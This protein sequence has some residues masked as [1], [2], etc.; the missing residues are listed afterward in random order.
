M[1]KIHVI[2][3]SEL[4]FG[5]FYLFGTNVRLLSC[6]PAATLVTRDFQDA[7]AQLLKVLI[8]QKVAKV[9]MLKEDFNLLQVSL[10]QK[11]ITSPS[12]LFEFW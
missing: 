5:V 12:I 8:M 7:F 4:I 9:L 11:K 2:I 1:V 6:H 10:S 3:S